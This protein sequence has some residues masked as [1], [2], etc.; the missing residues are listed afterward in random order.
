MLPVFKTRGGTYIFYD[1]TRQMPTF[2]SLIW[3]AV[4]EKKK[5]NRSHMSPGD[6]LFQ[7]NHNPKPIRFLKAYM[8]EKLPKDSKFAKIQESYIHY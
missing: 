1:G 6:A 4:T 5:H 3:D 8:F 2:W 7:K